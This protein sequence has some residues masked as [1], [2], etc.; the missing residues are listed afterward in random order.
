MEKRPTI[1]EPYIGY[2]DNPEISFV[3]TDF[4]VAEQMMIDYNQFSFWDFKHSG[5][6]GE[7]HINEFYDPRYNPIKE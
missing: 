6:F 4:D 1:T 2:F 3:T 5:E 7:E